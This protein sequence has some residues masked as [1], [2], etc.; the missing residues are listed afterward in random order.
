MAAGAGVAFAPFAILCF[1]IDRIFQIVN[2]STETQEKDDITHSCILWF[3][4]E[5]LQ[6]Q[7]K[8]HK[9]QADLLVTFKIGK[10]MHL[11]FFLRGS[12]PLI[13][14]PGT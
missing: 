7:Q 4:Y 1:T 14:S 2:D 6:N 11:P 13:E 3:S 12:R 8:T 10:V 9:V 5:F